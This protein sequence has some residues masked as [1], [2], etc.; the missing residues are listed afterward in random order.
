MDDTTRHNLRRM[1][2]DSF[3]PLFKEHEVDFELFT[4]L[5]P[6]IMG[7]IFAGKAKHLATFQAKYQEFGGNW[8]I[9]ETQRPD[10][11]E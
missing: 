11:E 9:P 2:M 5:T 8:E 3:I 1:G 4:S 10:L 7:C 6:L